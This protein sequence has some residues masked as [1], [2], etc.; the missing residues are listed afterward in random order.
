MSARILL[1]MVC[2]MLVPIRKGDLIVHFREILSK[3]EQCCE[4]SSILAFY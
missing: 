3:K 4:K 2:F 1:V